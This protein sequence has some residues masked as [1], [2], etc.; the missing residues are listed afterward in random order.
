MDEFL[1]SARLIHRLLISLSAVLFVFVLSPDDADKYRRSLKELRNFNA[2][3]DD[4][5]LAKYKEYLGGLAEQKSTDLKLLERI[6]AVVTERGGVVRDP[7]VRDNLFPEYGVRLLYTIMGLEEE[8]LDSIVDGNMSDIF[9]NLSKYS[10]LYIFEPDTV[11]FDKEIREK[12]SVSIQAGD[13][14]EYFEI[15]TQSIGIEDSTSNAAL[16]INGIAPYEAGFKRR[17]GNGSFVQKTGTITGELKP[18]KILSIAMWAENDPSIKKRFSFSENGFPFP[19]TREVWLEIHDKSVIEANFWL[20]SRW[21]E[22]DS[23]RSIKF[24][25]LAIPHDLVILCGPLGS[26]LISLYLL[27]HLKNTRYV[28]SKAY[29]D[30]A[31]WVFPWIGLFDNWLSKAVTISSICLVPFVINTSV[32]C[33]F[34]DYSRVIS[35]MGLCLLILIPLVSRALYKEILSMQ[36]IL[37]RPKLSV[38]P[39]KL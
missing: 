21:R 6:S 4:N 2:F 23:K 28:Y 35:W 11:N 24:L 33:R 13:E 31:K 5:G 30:N 12:F 25:G 9:D 22:I 34:F 15:G 10:E 1:K 7:L 18:Q 20:E 17:S 8:N 19:A 39:S 16:I 14:L 26:L 32:L 36:R 3:C 27:A 37:N 38:S 29:I